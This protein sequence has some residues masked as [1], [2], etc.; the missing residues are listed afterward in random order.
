MR[1][2]LLLEPN[3]GNKYPPIGLMKLATYHRM[4]GDQVTFYK[5]EMKQFVVDQIYQ[6]CL[7]KIA[8]IQPDVI[9]Y[10][11]EKEIKFYEE[12]LPKFEKF[13]QDRKADIKFD[14]CKVK[15]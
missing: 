8:K 15:N 2:I 10:L 9:W 3:Y 5:G 1:K 7:E 14:F 6:D 11:Y 12:L 13:I 4:L